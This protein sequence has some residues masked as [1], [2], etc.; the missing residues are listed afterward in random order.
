MSFVEESL[1]ARYVDAAKLE[2]SPSTPV[3]CILSPGVDPLNNVENLATQHYT[4]TELPTFL[5]ESYWVEQQ[6]PILFSL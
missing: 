3:F 6:T 5:L 2:S 1:G 4:N